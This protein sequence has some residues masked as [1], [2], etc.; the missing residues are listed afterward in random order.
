MG[1]AVEV[2]PETVNVM[3]LLAMPPTVT[4]TG[5]VVAPVGTEAT[6]LVLLQLVAVPAL[7]PLKVTVPVPCD[8][9]K[10]A[11]VIVTAVPIA[12]EVGLSMEMLGADAAGT[13]K[14]TPLLVT[15]LTVTVTLP[16]VAPLGTV[17][18]MLVLLQLVTIALL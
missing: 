7:A 9:P 10:F 2:E 5:P 6:T 8:A 12:P 3:P 13:V 1:N 4:T 15:L 18:E 14:V 17:T 11:P 16:V